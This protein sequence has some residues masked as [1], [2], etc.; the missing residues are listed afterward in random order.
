MAGHDIHGPAELP[1]P[2]DPPR[3]ES[4]VIYLYAS[5]LVLLLVIG[6][7]LTLLN[8]PGNWVMV[9]AAGLYAWLVPGE[10][11]LG[12]GWSVVVALVVLALLGEL[13]EG[14]AG[15]F[16][17]AKAGGSRRA[18]VLAMFGSIV[19]GIVGVFVGIP[20][21][22]VG[23]VI[24]AILFAAVGALVGAMLGENWY[25]RSLSESWRSGHAAF[26]GRIF[27]T[28]AKMAVGSAM[29]VVTVVALFF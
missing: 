19:G 9:G 11:T 20:I 22:L 8:M 15:A 4:A 2:R 17:V 3:D 12:I 23:P 24:A 7:F 27:G 1:H 6:W 28:L 14:V 26:W 10:G 18:A 29:V 25:G 5:L 13:I 16:G 21:P